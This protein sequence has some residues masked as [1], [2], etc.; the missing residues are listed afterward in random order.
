MEVIITCLWIKRY[1]NYKWSCLKLAEVQKPDRCCTE[2]WLAGW[3]LLKQ[4][5]GKW[6]HY[7]WGF[8]S[9]HHEY[10]AGSR[11]SDAGRATDSTANKALLEMPLACG[12]CSPTWKAAQARH[13]KISPVRSQVSHQVGSHKFMLAGT[14]NASLPCCYSSLKKPCSGQS[15]CLSLW[16]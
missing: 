9:S 3:C 6:S 10:L 13:C 12:E 5:A 8:P 11:G 14:E 1:W 4:L 16:G 7:D 15:T 2:I